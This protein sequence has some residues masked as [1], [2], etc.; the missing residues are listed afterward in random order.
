MLYHL[1]LQSNVRFGPLDVLVSG[2]GSG[3]W[4]FF[5][6]SGYLLYRPFVVGTVDP[7]SYALKRAARILPGY[8]VALIALIVLTG[9]RLPFEHP[10]A[11]LTIT[12]S[13]DK[14]LRAFLGP[15]WTLSAEVLFYITLPLIARLASGRQFRVLLPLAT[16][17]IVA[18][19]I[20]RYTATP[21][22]VF[23]VDVYPLVFFGF[24]PGMLLAVLEV[25]RPEAFRELA[26]ARYLVLGLFLIALG[27]VTAVYPLP[28]G[29]MFGTPLA[30]GW[31]LNHRLPGSRALIF[32]GGASYSLYL[33]HSDLIWE[34]GPVGAL[35]AIVGAC[36][37]WALVERPILDMAQRV[38]SRWRSATPL[39]EPA[40]A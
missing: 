1:W 9:N 19:L 12:S 38:A 22:N 36:L 11:Y 28:I 31:L 5:V 14:N 34:F 3:V 16:L 37:S 32:V 40:A 30:A 26:R 24:V 25:S 7:R 23:F 2:G 15:A 27:C 20:Q 6:L 8:F 10:V 21:A 29:A 13:Y 35:I 33:L 18:S 39:S 17:S 4:V